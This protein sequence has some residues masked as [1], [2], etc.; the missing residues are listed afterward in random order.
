MS[1]A[2]ASADARWALVGHG[3]FADN[4]GCLSLREYPCTIGRRTGVTLQVTHLSVSGLHA[5]LNQVDGDLVL[6]DL[7][8]RNGTF[9][10]GKRLRAPETIQQGD[11]VQFGETVFRLNRETTHSQSITPSASEVCDLALALAQFDKLM[12]ERAFISHFQPIVT[13]EEGNPIVAFEALA[14]SRLFGL[15]SPMMMFR[16]AAHFNQEAELS[17]LLRDDAVATTNSYG[18]PHLF[19]NTHPAELKDLGKLVQSLRELRRLFPKQLLTLEVHEASLLDMTSIRMLRLALR[20]LNMGLAYDDFGAGQ[21]RFT[22][23][24]EAR[25]DYLKFDMKFIRGIHQAPANR[26]QLLA[27]LVRMAT[28]LGIVPLAEGVETEPEAECGKQ[29][30]FQLFQGYLFGRP[31][32]PEKWLQNEAEVRLS[33]SGA[34]R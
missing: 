2:I 19:L 3:V 5:E 33:S 26:Q 4:F 23:L 20:D 18:S 14:R 15:T 16:A 7:G 31:D 25:P 6:T 8:S 29:M 32:A 21:A 9:V 27:S 30:G 34:R 28:D 11:L 22:E 13:V 17:S 24:V 12:S 10:N 1:A